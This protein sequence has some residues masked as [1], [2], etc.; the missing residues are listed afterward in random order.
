M[1]VWRAADPDISVPN[2]E[3]FPS[4]EAMADWKNQ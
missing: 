2:G 3:T 1:Q 4:P